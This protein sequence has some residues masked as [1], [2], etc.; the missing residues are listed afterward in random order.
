MNSKSC[1]CFAIQASKPKDEDDGNK[2]GKCDK[3]F[4]GATDPCT[5]SKSGNTRTGTASKE[6]L[7]CIQNQGQGTKGKGVGTEV[8]PPQVV[9]LLAARWV[10]GV[11]VATA[12]G[13]SRLKVRCLLEFENRGNSAC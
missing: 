7:A 11:V 13:L 2:S 8:V 12:A 6:M 10:F 9:V 4:T 5:C 3:N 1:G